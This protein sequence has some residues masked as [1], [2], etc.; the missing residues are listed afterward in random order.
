MTQA[1]EVLASYEQYLRSL[2]Q[3]SSSDMKEALRIN[4]VYID[5]CTE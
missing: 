4:P 1:K 3:M 5:F 2:G